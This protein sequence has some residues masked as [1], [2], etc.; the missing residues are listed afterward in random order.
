MNKYFWMHSV[1]TRIIKKYL[2]EY[3][4]VPAYVIDMVVDVVQV[5]QTNQ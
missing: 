3:V 5:I 2:H 4:Q 1:L